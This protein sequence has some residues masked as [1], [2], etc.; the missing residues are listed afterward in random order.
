MCVCVCV[1]VCVHVRACVRA[2]VC[3]CVCVCVHDCVGFIGVQVKCQIIYC[4]N[5][6]RERSAAQ[7]FLIL[8]Y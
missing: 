3:V 5:S 7:P 8:N 1:C 6:L 2:R 4:T